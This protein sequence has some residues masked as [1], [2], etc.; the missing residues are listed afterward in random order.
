MDTVSCSESLKRWEQEIGWDDLS[1]T[2]KT[3]IEYGCGSGR[4][5]DIA[6][7]YNPELAVGI[8]ISDAVDAAYL[9]LGNRNNI[10][11]VQAD[12]FNPP[13]RKNTFDFAYS[14]GVLHHTPE[15][16]RAFHTMTSLVSCNGSVGLSLYEISLFDRPS[17]NSVKQ[18]MIELLWS[19]NMLRVEFF[20]IFT[21]RVP[22]YV[23][24]CYCKYIIPP[25]HYL[26]KIP[27]LRYFRY[28]LPST[29]YP[30]LPV[31][32]S[33]LDTHDTYATKIV[34]MYRHKDI[35]QWFKRARLVDIDISNSIPGWV[36]LT[37]RR[38]SERQEQMSTLVEN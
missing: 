33:M 30:N 2:N 14:I 8:D 27:I 22:S 37:G 17:Y 11:I 10:L 25:L 12:I 1:L 38:P 16:E 21:T 23:M 20:R 6:S 4:F 19:I 35:F 32:W 28:L 29:C 26:N 15:P 34:H 13:F 7:S 18:S 3:I 36:S 5:L 24:I 31:E 9:N